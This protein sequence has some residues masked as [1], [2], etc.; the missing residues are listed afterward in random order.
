MPFLACSIVIAPIL[1]EEDVMFVIELD[2]LSIGTIKTPIHTELISKLVHIQDLS[3]VKP[4]SKQ[5]IELVCVLAVN[6]PVPPNTY[7]KL[8]SI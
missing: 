6:L 3:I 8:S 2:L 7:L 5:P 4:I 1:Y